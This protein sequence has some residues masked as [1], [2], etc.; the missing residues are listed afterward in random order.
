MT[1]LYAFGDVYD[2]MVSHYTADIAFYVQ[3]A[4]KAEPPVL[5]LACGTGRVLIPTAQA[6]VPIWGLDLTP[7]MLARA[8]RKI[9]ALPAGVQARITIGQGDM[10]YFNLPQR[11]GLVTIPFR[12][13]LH[14]MT[15]Q[16]QLAALVNIRRHL[17]PGG[18]LALNFFQ[19]NIPTIAVH[20]TPTGNALKFFQ[21]WRDPETGRRVVCWETRRYYPATQVIHERRILE[22]V[23]EN[24]KVLDR[25]H[26][27]LTLRWI[28][29]YEFEH[30]LARAGLEIEALYGDFD[31]RPFNES[32]NEL[33]WIARR[34][35]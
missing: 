5:E 15:V 17:R 3:Q 29:R 14:L 31:R 18:R 33:I 13:F 1:D 12:S 4:Q 6:G 23:D 8:E 16:E 19:P 11:F 20:L 2:Q 28:Y 26:H 30:L 34:A 25:Q 24:G 32:S 27:S 35:N 9:A 22:T 7:A 21:E 10:R